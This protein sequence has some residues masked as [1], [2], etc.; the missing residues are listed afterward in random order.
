MGV[1]GFFKLPQYNVFDY[2][3]RF[4]DPEKDERKEKLN[5]IRK[6]KGKLAQDDDEQ[7]KPG[8]AIKGSFR[9]KMTRTSYRTR[10]ST[11]RV[12]VILFALILLVYVIFVSDLSAFIKLF[13]Q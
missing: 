7:S 5:E 2:K 10:S 9:S 8:S 3:P 11:I 1:G 4:F 13:D 12:L 6:S